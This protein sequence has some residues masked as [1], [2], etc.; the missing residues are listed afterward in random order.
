MS[1]TRT[2]SL[3]CKT[4]L[5]LDATSAHNVA[6]YPA[7]KLETNF[8][9]QYWKSTA[10][11][12]FKLTNNTGGS[13]DCDYLLLVNL[14]VSGILTNIQIYNS[15][16]VST[17]I[18]TASDFAWYKGQAFISLDAPTIDNTKFFEIYVNTT[19]TAYCGVARGIDESDIKVASI[20]YKQDRA[21]QLRNKPGIFETEGGAIYTRE[22][23]TLLRNWSL[24]YD[25]HALSD[26]DSFNFDTGLQEDMTTCG[27]YIP[28]TRTDYLASHSAIWGK[29]VDKSE[30]ETSKGG[31]RVSGNVK[32]MEL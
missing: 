15:D 8:R 17:Q 21:A 24:N 9:G 7:S 6:G 3:I 13:L 2:K 1:L 26:W 29:I 25:F 20:N 14:W 16:D 19:G 12:K 32:I 18:L 4:F 11:Y 30:T 27:L 5:D 22:K 23:G 31:S 10:G 28:N